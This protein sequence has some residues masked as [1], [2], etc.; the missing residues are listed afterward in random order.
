MHRSINASGHKALIS[1]LRWKCGQGRRERRHNNILSTKHAARQIFAHGQLWDTQF[2]M[3]DTGCLQLLSSDIASLRSRFGSIA[4]PENLWTWRSSQRKGS[5]ET[6]IS[7]QSEKDHLQGDSISNKK[8]HQISWKYLTSTPTGTGVTN[9][10]Q[11]YCHPR[12]SKTGRS[13]LHVIILL[14][15]HSEFTMVFPNPGK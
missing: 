11:S 1:I 14:A 7:K 15:L 3:Q 8:K 6:L 12:T 9:E 5:W 4:L 13:L 10:A 2:Q